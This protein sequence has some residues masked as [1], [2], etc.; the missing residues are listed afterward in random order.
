M[1]AK[2]L[3]DRTIEVAVV[4]LEGCGTS[5]I[6]D[7][8]LM[9]D[10]G[11]FIIGSSETAPNQDI[12][13]KVDPENILNP[14]DA[15]VDNIEGVCVAYDNGVHRV[16]VTTGSVE[17]AQMMRDMFGSDLYVIGILDGL[18]EKDEERARELMDIIVKD[19]SIEFVTEFGKALRL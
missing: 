14:E 11:T 4:C 1:L 18:Q 12:I 5:L 9:R 17:D 8:S 7:P 3:D 16:A 19:D 13:S 15:K 10:V 6:S 2:A